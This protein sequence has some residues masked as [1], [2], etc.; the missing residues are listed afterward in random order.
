MADGNILLKLARGSIESAFGIPGS[1]IENSPWLQQPGATFVT[2]AMYGDLRGCIGS[3]E[4]WR[5]LREDVC[6]NALSAAFRDP[7]FPPLQKHELGD[8]RLEVSLLSP[9]QP[10]SFT[11]E[12]DALAQLRPGEDGVVLETGHHRGTFLPQVWEQLPSPRKFMAHLKRKA[13][14]PENFWSPDV[15]LH[16]YTVEKWKEQPHDGCQRPK[17]Q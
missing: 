17:T 5:T 16:R 1:P 12:I 7:R 6:Q 9:Q 3:L 8:V 10:M 13:G 15:K 2:L 4:A 11:D 14:L